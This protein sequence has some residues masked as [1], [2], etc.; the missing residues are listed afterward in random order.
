MCSVEQPV[1]HT[2]KK[3]FELRQI[4]LLP[5]LLFIGLIRL[6]QIGLSPVLPKSCRFTPSCSQYG[7]A[8]FRKYNLI[9]AMY[10]TTW[11]VIRCNPFCKGGYDP[12]P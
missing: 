9:K 5:N 11:R 2:A 3:K 6:Y 12:L 8:A 4:I 10:L 1:C 7:L